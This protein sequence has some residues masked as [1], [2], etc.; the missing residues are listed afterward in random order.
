[1]SPESISA[2]M[3]NEAIDNCLFGINK[4]PIPVVAEFTSGQ[5]FPIEKA[6]YVEGRAAA[7]KILVDCEGEENSLREKIKELEGEIEN[8]QSEIKDA[9][10]DKD[11]A[12][13]E[14]EKWTDNFGDDPDTTKTLWDNI[15]E[16]I[17][18]FAHT[19]EINLVHN[20]AKN[21]SNLREEYEKKVQLLSEADEV[22][23]ELKLENLAAK[24]EIANLKV[25]NRA[26]ADT[27]EKLLPEE[28]Q[29][30]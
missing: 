19:A 6:Y 28:D 18:E 9:K 1:M 13:E 8:Y 7:I 21:I 20:D 14:L 2:Y 17:R 23:G 11:D 12:Q 4:C 5:E 29:K 24:R 22:I 26:L 25:D 30:T 10:D 16:E 3:R 27:L 15:E